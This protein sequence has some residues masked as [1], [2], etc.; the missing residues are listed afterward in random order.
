MHL[1]AP[2]SHPSMKVVVQILEG[3][4][5]KLT[6]PPILLIPLPLL[7]RFNASIL[8]R[9]LNQELEVIPKLD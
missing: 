8:A 1:V 7:T 3:K 2:D 9:H 5:D 4:G 6:V